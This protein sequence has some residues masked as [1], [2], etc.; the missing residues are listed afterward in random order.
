[1]QAHYAEAFEREMGC[2]EADW[3]AALPGAVGSRPLVLDAGAARVLIDGGEL[4]LAWHVLA[5]RRIALL[6][7]PRLVVGF[8]FER[9]DEASRQRFM[10]YFDLFT[11][12][13]GG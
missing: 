2:T 3:L 10:R 9:V 12:R 13:G 5:P 6:Q 1:M 7:I 8:R 11:Q 4:H